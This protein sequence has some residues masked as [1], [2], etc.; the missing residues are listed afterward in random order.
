[1][2]LADPCTG[3]AWATVTVGWP[4][5]WS[6]SSLASPTAAGICWWLAPSTPDQ[7]WHPSFHCAG[8]Q[9]SGADC[10]GGGSGMSHRA[11]RK[12]VYT[13]ISLVIKP[14]FWVIKD[15]DQNWNLKSSKTGISHNYS[16]SQ[17]DK[18]YPRMS[19][20]VIYPRISLWYFVWNRILRVDL[21]KP[22]LYKLFIFPTEK[23][24]HGISQYKRTCPG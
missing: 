5:P 14:L 19:L 21:N 2:E 4:G 15:Y 9:W 17:F 6:P 1:M 12:P 20:L 11:A 8:R 24:E 23:N 3:L 13:M 16:I 10:A 22:N 18:R 7:V